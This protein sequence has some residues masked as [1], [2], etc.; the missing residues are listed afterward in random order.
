MDTIECLKTRRSI[1]RFIEDKLVDKD[2][3]ETIIDC[4][5]LAPSANNIQPWQFVVVTDKSIRKQLADITD[6]GKFI[7]QAPV[8]IT[9]FCED[10]KYYI[11]DGVAAT[12]NIL[13][14]IHALGLSACWVAGDKKHYAED[15]RK[16]LG[17]P[18]KY[19]LISFIPLGYSNDKSA[20]KKKS[21]NEVI[22]WEKF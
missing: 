19:K 5:R 13:L 2:V 18:S 1:R 12:E 9:V 4:A 14:A 21:L 3:I 22:H 8:C 10:T 7:T 6:H 15:V 20:V 17:V 11:E 16:L